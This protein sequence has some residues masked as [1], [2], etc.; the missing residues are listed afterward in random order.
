MQPNPKQRGPNLALYEVLQR[1]GESVTHMGCGGML[2]QVL[3]KSERL[4]GY[5]VRFAPE[6]LPGPIFCRECG[7]RAG[8]QVTR[9]LKQRR[10]MEN[11][12]VGPG[13]NDLQANYYTDRVREGRKR[14]HVTYRYWEWIP[15]PAEEEEPRDLPRLSAESAERLL[16]AILEADDMPQRKRKRTPRRIRERRSGGTATGRIVVEIPAPVYNVG[17]PNR[18]PPLAPMK[19][20]PTDMMMDD[21][22]WIVRHCNED[23][24]Y[25]YVALDR[26]FWTKERALEA[27]KLARNE[28]FNTM[29]DFLNAV[30]GLGQQ[31]LIPLASVVISKDLQSVRKHKFPPVPEPVEEDVEF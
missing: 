11:V 31:H 26:A 3:S 13:R 12:F 23:D 6:N 16:S 14:F 20:M 21:G 24:I 5:H 28:F 8:R 4:P 7:H 30:L 27:R 19:H 25:W 2:V 10:G 29:D 22:S 18:P 15:L 1:S 17:L 9:V